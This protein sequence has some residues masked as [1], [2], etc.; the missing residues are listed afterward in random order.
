MKYRRISP[1][2][3]RRVED[4]A[5]DVRVVSLFRNGANQAVRIPREFELPGTEARLRRD[6]D[7]LILEPVP[8]L[9]MHDLIRAWAQEAPLEEGIPEFPDTPPEPIS[10]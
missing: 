6:G 5:D 4:S 1:A 10:F 9:S 2:T 7:R 3:P 8:A